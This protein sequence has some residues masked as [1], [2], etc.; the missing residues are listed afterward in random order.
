MFYN[1]LVMGGRKWS[2]VPFFS[3]PAITAGGCPRW[4]GN[5]PGGEMFG[6][7]CSRGNVLHSVFTVLPLFSFEWRNDDCQDS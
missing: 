3:I 5:C 6:G 2:L 1:R 7:I 4:E